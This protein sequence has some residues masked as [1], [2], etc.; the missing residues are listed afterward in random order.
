M[1]FRAWKCGLIAHAFR[2]ELFL[3]KKNCCTFPFTTYFCVLVFSVYI[4]SS[5]Y[6]ISAQKY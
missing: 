4:Y 6:K 2:I 5:E 1:A 3:E